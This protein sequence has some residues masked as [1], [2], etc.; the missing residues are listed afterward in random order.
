MLSSIF[1]AVA[2]AQSE[3]HG[4][5][6]Q[7]QG[8]QG[9]A[10]GRFQGCTDGRNN[11]KGA[12]ASYGVPPACLWLSVISVYVLGTYRMQ[13]RATQWQREAGLLPLEPQVTVYQTMKAEPV[14]EPRLMS[15]V[16]G[17]PDA[18]MTLNLS[19]NLGQSMNPGYQLRDGFQQESCM[20][21]DFI[22]DQDEVCYSLTALSAYQQCTEYCSLASLRKMP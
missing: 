3:Y 4:S 20:K 6:R 1:V 11:T 19:R 9:V 2:K 21:S 13:Q 7:G 5:R 16:Q 14:A 17:D 22:W 15:T 12:K 10:Y 8:L 18:F